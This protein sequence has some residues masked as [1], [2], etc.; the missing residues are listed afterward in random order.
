MCSIFLYILEHALGVTRFE[1]YYYY[2]I[3]TLHMTSGN[4]KAEYSAS[5][6]YVPSYITCTLF[7]LMP[8][9][10]ILN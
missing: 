2:Y 6:H 8:P 7:Y 1:I 4:V 3:N 5:L 9:L 10:G